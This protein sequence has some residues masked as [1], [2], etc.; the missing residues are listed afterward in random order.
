[1]SVIP[2][3]EIGSESFED[4]LSELR[5]EI[6]S[7]QL[8]G[9]IGLFDVFAQEAR[10]ARSWLA[11][12]LNGLPPGSEVLEVGAGLML[13]A[14]QLRR[15]GFAVTAL[16]PIGPGF[17]VFSGLQ[18]MVLGYA[19]ERGCAPEL[20]SLPVESLTASRVFSFAY[21]VNVMEHVADVPTALARVVSSLKP[22]GRYR[23]T[24]PNYLFPYEPHFNIPTFFSKRLT[25]LAF[26]RKIW[27][28]TKV[29]DPEAT[30]NSLNWITVPEVRRALAKMEH[31]RFWFDGSLLEST[32]AR[33]AN[34]PVFAARRSPWVRKLISS[35]VRFGL[36][37]AARFV[38]STLQPI[39][40]CHVLVGAENS[41]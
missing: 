39:I 40:D 35:A 34:D 30:W 24:C 37:R 26:R 36:H 25:A 29:P 4:F 6:S 9:S 14:C 38:P 21:S 2:S 27:N 8:S 10:V 20:I 12:S 18:R 22:G 28:S 33:V 1:M 23:F 31:V 32:L 5:T 13:L 17:D 41:A 7:G 19:K 16:E 15:E 11:T 3:R